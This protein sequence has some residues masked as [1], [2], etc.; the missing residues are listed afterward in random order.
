MFDLIRSIIRWIIIA[1]IIAL[2]IIFISKMTQKKPKVSSTLNSGIRTI[3]DTATTAK[4]TIE[5]SLKPIDN[6]TEQQNETLVVDSPD[7]ATQDGIGLVIGII[8]TGSGFY[9]IY[10]HKMITE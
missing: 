7:T 5:D 9:Y 1:I 10:K 2:V 6:V 3:K 8:I 4:D